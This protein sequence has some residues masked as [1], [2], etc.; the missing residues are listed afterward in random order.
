MRKPV[1]KKPAEKINSKIE[2]IILEK[3]R[4]PFLVQLKYAFQ[5]DTKLYL[6][7]DFVEGSN[8][9]RKKRKK[10]DFFFVLFLPKTKN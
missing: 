2:R 7:M 3:I 4:S 1:L 6:V 5:S 10:K 8:N 9:L